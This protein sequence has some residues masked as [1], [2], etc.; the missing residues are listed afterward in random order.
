VKSLRLITGNNRTEL[1][2]GSVGRGMLR[3]IPVHDPARADVK[4]DKDVEC[5]KSGRE[6]A[7]NSCS[8]GIFADHS[9]VR[10]V[11]ANNVVL[12]EPLQ[13]PPHHM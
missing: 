10:A 13:L 4:D 6:L 7:A 11:P 8:V 3:H 2:H 1:L 9:P 5:A 12:L